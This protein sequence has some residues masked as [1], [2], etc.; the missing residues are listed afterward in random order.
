MGG[1]GG[2]EGV[3]GW[4]GAVGRAIDRGRGGGGYGMLDGLG[5]HCCGTLDAEGFE[6]GGGEG[7]WDALMQGKADR[8]VSDSAAI[9]CILL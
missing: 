5:K 6:R 1:R 7:V 9:P 2:R 3:G 8:D 4:G